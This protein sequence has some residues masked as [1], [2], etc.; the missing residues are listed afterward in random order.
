MVAKSV[1][2][3]DKL[4]SD[5]DELRGDRKFTEVVAEALAYWVRLARRIRE[6]AVIAQA[7]GHIGPDQR[8]EEQELAQLAQKSSLEVLEDLDAGSQTG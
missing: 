7:L 2:L 1:R 4:A 3:P 6:D 5:V 8:R